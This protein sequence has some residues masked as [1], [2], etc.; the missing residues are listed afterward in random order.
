MTTNFTTFAFPSTGAPTPRT[1]PARLAEVHNVLDFGATGNGTTD[2]L[3]AIRAAIDWQTSTNYRGTIYFPP[4][5]YYVSAPIDF[6]A[7]WTPS[8]Q[9][10]GLFIS[11]LG[12]MGRSIIVG[13]FADYVLR[14]GIEGPPRYG[15]PWLIDKLT[16][17]NRH[18][19]GGG[20][21]LGA[22]QCAAI[23]DCD[24]TADI[25]IN[26]DN[27]ENPIDVAGGGANVNGAFECLIENCNLRPYNTRRAGSI[28][29]YKCSDG[30]VTNCTII[31]FESGI[32][33]A[34]GQG[35]ASILGTYFE[36]NTYG[37]RPGAAI[38]AWGVGTGGVFTLE[39]CHFKN[40]GIAING[41]TS[42]I[43]RGVY[44]E[45]TTGSI[46][47]NPQYGMLFTS[48]RTA[49]SFKGISI[50]G[51]FQQYGVSLGGGETIKNSG[52]YVG[53]GSLNSISSPSKNWELPTTAMSVK[54]SAINKASVFKVAQ[55]PGYTATVTAMSWSAGVVTVTFSTPIDVSPLTTRTAHVTVAGMTPSG[56]NGL[57]TGGTILNYKQLSFSLVS[58]PGPAAVMGTVFFTTEGYGIRNAYEGDT[59]NVSDA[60]TATW[61]AAVT[62]GGGSNHVKVRFTSS[63]WTVMGV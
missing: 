39:G 40:N 12:E 5:T 20:I 10:T 21:R 32:R 29:I 57:H 6:S 45:A 2:D 27:T 62:A 1:L 61:G 17:I 46:P 33:T 24:I 4:G 42:G 15:G 48:G 31:G 30:P 54:F 9:F 60:N 19:G 35:G 59:Y 11:W 58:D 22:V 23:R 47:G 16:I 7:L 52:T 25:A 51:D 36:G 13:D 18:A 49:G 8:Q 41:L 37:F 34:S 43:Y 38:E 50:V 26:E 55:L 44:I 56:Y 63:K 3:A 14:R 53:V 28:G